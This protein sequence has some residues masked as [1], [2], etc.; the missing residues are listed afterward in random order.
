MEN[1]SLPVLHKIAAV[2][3]RTGL[4]RS[5]IYRQISAGEIHVVKIGRAVRITEVE[6]SRYINSL[7]LNA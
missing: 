6:L 5:A 7:T 2:C 4:S 1:Q 3:Q